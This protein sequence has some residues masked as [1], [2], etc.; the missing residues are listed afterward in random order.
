MKLSVHFPF[1][2]SIFLL[3][4]EIIF[5]L[6]FILSLLPSLI[7]IVFILIKNMQKISWNILW[8]MN[9]VINRI[10]TIFFQFFTLL[11]KIAQ[12]PS[13]SKHLLDQLFLLNFLAHGC[14]LFLFNTELNFCLLDLFLTAFVQIA[15]SHPSHLMS[16]PENSC[17]NSVLKF[18]FH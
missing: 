3:W 2:L 12:R 13:Q 14:R 15:Y 8:S 9:I 6:R 4:W 17:L 16:S 11:P 10:R 5:V 18:V 1:I 7:I